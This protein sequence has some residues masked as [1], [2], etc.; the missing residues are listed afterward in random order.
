MY[1]ITVWDGPK[2]GLELVV[3]ISFDE[4]QNISEIHFNFR[5]II[6]LQI[7]LDIFLSDYLD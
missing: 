2:S 7:L 5:K 3:S 1:F 4:N 6:F